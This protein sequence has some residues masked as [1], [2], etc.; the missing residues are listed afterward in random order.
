MYFVQL[1]IA[2]QNPKTPLDHPNGFK[3]SESLLALRGRLNCWT[4]RLFRKMGLRLSLVIGCFTSFTLNAFP[5]KFL[6]SSTASFGTS[7]CLILTSLAFSSFWTLDLFLSDSR[8]SLKA[9]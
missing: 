7:I 2:P 5:V 8:R 4:I 9:F 6:A 1:R 3:S